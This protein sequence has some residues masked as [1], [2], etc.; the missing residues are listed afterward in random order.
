MIYKEFFNCAINF[1]FDSNQKERVKIYYESFKT[2]P[3][4]DNTA[5]DAYRDKVFVI[6]LQHQL[7]DD[8]YLFITK[9]SIN[10]IKFRKKEKSLSCL[11][12]QNSIGWSWEQIPYISVVSC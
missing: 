12:W 2:I 10:F 1:K 11:N 6:K 3:F 5:W 4:L 8:Q 9:T 7:L